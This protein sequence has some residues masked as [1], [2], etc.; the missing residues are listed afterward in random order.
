M[1]TH[2]SRSRVQLELG[3]NDAGRALSSEEFA[4]A[5]YEEPWKYEREKGRLIVMSPDGKRHVL[6]MSPW[7]KRLMV[8]WADN[9]RI[10]DLVSPNAWVRV[11][12]GTDRIGD[13]CV[14]LAHDPPVLNIPD[15]V[16]EMMFEIVSPGRKSRDRDYVKKR[17][18]YYQ[19]GVREYVVVDRF[20]K[21]VTVHSHTP[22]G[23]QEQI[24]KRG[25][26]YQS[27]LLPGL[28]IPLDEVLSP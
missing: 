17:N 18:E 5:I 28:A 24:L 13:I 4:D 23:Y 7:L 21:Q 1:A 6:T 2:E 27:P 19:L 22:E 16:P 11:D 8:Y 12:D 10:V 14:Y 9:P 26:L 25:D 20:K 15:Q 3:P